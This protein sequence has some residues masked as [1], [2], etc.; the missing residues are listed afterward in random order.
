MIVFDDRPPPKCSVASMCIAACTTKVNN[1]RHPWKLRPYQLGEDLSAATSWQED[2]SYFAPFLIQYVECG[3]SICLEASSMSRRHCDRTT[4]DLPGS[5]HELDC[6]LSLIV[7]ARTNRVYCFVSNV[8]LL[9]VCL[10]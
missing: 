9:E 7:A 2:P 4:A 6:C 3:H 8:M 1:S 10:K 5:S